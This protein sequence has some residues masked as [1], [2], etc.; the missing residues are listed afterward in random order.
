LWIAG[1]GYPDRPAL[2]RG[3]QIDG[4]N[5]LRFE[6]GVD[7]A[8]ELRFEGA[9]LGQG[10]RHQPSYTRVS[11]PGCYAYQVDGLGLS[12]VIVFEAVAEKPGG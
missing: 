8:G 2:I 3:G 10:W 4:Q 1:P 9:D 7:P 12:E 5:E 11:G 6:D